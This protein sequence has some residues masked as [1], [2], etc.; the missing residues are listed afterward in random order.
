MVRQSLFAIALA[1][2]VILIG[3]ADPDEFAVFEAEG[4][5]GLPECYAEQFP[6]E[7]SF[8]A[9]RTRDGRTGIFL[10]TPADVKHDSDAVYLEVRNLDAAAAGEPL[11]LSQ[12]TGTDARGKM[13]FFSSCPREPQ[14]LLL[15]GSIQFN[16]FDPDAGGIIDGELVDAS[17]LGARSGEVVIEQVTGQWRFIV[18]RGPPHED[19]YALPDRP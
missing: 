14:S 5:D 4:V 18:R 3:C 15:R 2:M 9:A 10:Q 19:F 13:V 16:S 17:A 1:K 7:P 11:E 6:F 8:L 12:T